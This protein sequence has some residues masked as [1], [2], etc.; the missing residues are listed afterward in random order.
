M[1]SSTPSRRS[2][3]VATGVAVAALAALASVSPV[4]AAAPEPPVQVQKNFFELTFSPAGGSSATGVGLLAANTSGNSGPSLAVEISGLP[5]DTPYRARLAG[6]AD[7]DTVPTTCAGDLAAFSPNNFSYLGDD[8]IETGDEGVLRWT[9][10][11]MPAFAGDALRDLNAGEPAV[12]IVDAANKI[13]ACA[14]LG[15]TTNLI[16]NPTSRNFPVAL[17]GGRSPVYLNNSGIKVSG[18][19]N[20]TATLLTYD[21][22]FVGNNLI[23]STAG[24]LE[25]HIMMLRSSDNCGDGSL[26]TAL[27]NVEQM[28][29]NYGNPT[30]PVTD[31]NL[32][33]AWGRSPLSSTGELRVQGST[34][35]STS[36]HNVVKDWGIVLLGLESGSTTPRNGPNT[37]QIRQTIPSACVAFVDKDS[38]VGPSTVADA[39]TLNELINAVDYNTAKDPEILRL[40]NAFFGREPDV[41]GVKYWIA[42]SRGQIDGKTYGTLPIAGFFA[43]GTEFKN[44][45]ADAPNNSVFLERVYLNI[46]GRQGEAGGV[47]YWT[48]ILN[49]TNNSGKNPT[50]QVGSRAEVVYYVAINTEFVN[51]KPYLPGN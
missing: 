40:Y 13:V 46:L 2:W 25:N 31:A 23:N 39:T 12:V 38:E 19:V 29:T 20:L 3:K 34:I 22:T 37:L 14:P 41:A 7:A 42:V 27:Q 5:A 8:T 48:D 49:G 16:K 28:I 26:T 33:D 17:T 10:D 9:Y 4:A 21:F 6:P 32:V 44:T 43:Q 50:R 30:T 35:L 24:G 1:H 47:A 51:R 15:G 45:Y 11:S 18:N 36:D